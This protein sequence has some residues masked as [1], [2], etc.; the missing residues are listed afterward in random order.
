[1]SENLNMERTR[2]KA[3]QP[4]KPTAGATQAPPPLAGPQRMG[5][6]RSGPVA[7]PPAT[8]NRVAE[9]QVTAHLMTLE[10][11]LFCVFQ[12]PGGPPPDPVTSLPGVRITLA[13][14]AAGRPEAVNVSTFRGDG[15]LDG[16]AALV[17]VASG[18][19]QILVTIYQDKGQDAAPRL[20]VL[21]LS[22]EANAAL[23]PRQQPSPTTER[24]GIAAAPV[25]PTAEVMAHV[26]RMGDVTCNLGDWV[27]TRGSGQWMEGFGIAPNKPMAVP[28]IE[29][30][31]VLGRNWL[32]PWVEG[33]K[34]CGSRGMALPLLGLKV[35]LK[36]EAAKAFACSYSGTFV[37]GSTAGPVEGGEVCEAESLAALEAF[38]IVIRPR[39]TKPAS[40]RGD[41]K[42]LPG[43][44]PVQDK[45]TSKAATEA[46]LPAPISTT[47]KT[48]AK[49]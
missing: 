16:T 11:G 1:M 13:P 10:A 41:D 23:T 46:A 34:Y 24:V 9:L 49:L 26:Q 4:G 8:G 19:A 18:S 45:T 38:Q 29:Y 32:S 28:D 14:G 3:D 12:T 30:Q 48:R 21:R 39:D 7:A 27:G 5:S 2:V 37:D 31:A 15:W 47:P 33:G 20:Q 43:K 17:R 44:P 36:G 6:N 40:G 42:K 25:G 22:G 35:R